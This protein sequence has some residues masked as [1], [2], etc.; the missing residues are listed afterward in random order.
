MARYAYVNTTTGRFIKWFVA[1]YLEHQHQ[2]SLEEILHWL[3][4]EEDYATPLDELENLCDGLREE[5]KHLHILQWITRKL[6]GALRD[7]REFSHKATDF[8][9]A[10]VGRCGIDD[11][12]VRLINET[13]GKRVGTL[14]DLQLRKKESE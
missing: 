12:D 14:H 7:E 9:T 10:L 8:F 13:T 1:Q 2:P 6:I 5:A 3:R 4:H 11:Y